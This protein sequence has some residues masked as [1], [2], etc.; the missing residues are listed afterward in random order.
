MIILNIL[1]HSTSL[2]F[3]FYFS[4]CGRD[5]SKKF[6][7]KRTNTMEQMI[8]LL[9]FSCYQTLFRIIYLLQLLSLWLCF[10]STSASDMCVYACVCIFFP[11]FT[12]IR[13]RVFQ[14]R[15]FSRYI[16]LHALYILSSFFPLFHF[17]NHRQNYYFSSSFYSAGADGFT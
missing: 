13:T 3:L 5:S 6:L 15:F 16:T 17:F 8:S 9:F 12:H 10:H 4:P 14:N 1:E 11:L 7:R 2:F